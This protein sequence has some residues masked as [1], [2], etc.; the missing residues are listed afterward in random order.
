MLL[1]IGCKLLHLNAWL[2]EFHHHVGIFMSGFTVDGSEIRKKLAC[3]KTLQSRRIKLLSY[4][5][6]A[7]SLITISMSSTTWKVEILKLF[8]KVADLSIYIFGNKATDG[9]Y[10]SIYWFPGFGFDSGP[11][12]QPCFQIFH[13]FPI[14]G[15]DSNIEPWGYK[16]QPAFTWVDLYEK[17]NKK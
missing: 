14:I 16:S 10:G 5:C 17:N 3:I 7:G 8:S 15:A 4:K 12:L 13:D 11:N 2:E 6:I 1:C 9:T